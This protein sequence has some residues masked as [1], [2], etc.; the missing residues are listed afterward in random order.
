MK[1]VELMMAASARPGVE[2]SYVIFNALIQA[3]ER[4]KNEFQMEKH[5]DAELRDRQATKTKLYTVRELRQNELL[6]KQVGFTDDPKLN[7]EDQVPLSKTV[8]WLPAK[9]L[10]NI[11]WQHHAFMK[12]IS[13]SDKDEPTEAQK[14][15]LAEI[16][17][18]RDREIDSFLPR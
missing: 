10:F 9:D 12:E 13:V 7:D 18:Q 16:E 15:K 11:V 6:A 3:I 1:L 5:I 8:G 17:K 4:V 2:K 14:A